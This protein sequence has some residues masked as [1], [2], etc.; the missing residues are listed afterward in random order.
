M[1]TFKAS[2]IIASNAKIPSWVLRVLRS[3]SYDVM[4][5]NYN[6]SGPENIIFE[7]E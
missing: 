4:S 7:S 6:T 5:S 2:K 3:W 1:T